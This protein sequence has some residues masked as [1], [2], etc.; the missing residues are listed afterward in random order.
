MI[1]NLTPTGGTALLPS[2]EA[3]LGVVAEVVRLKLQHAA[4]TAEMESEVTAVQKRFAARL[5]TLAQKIGERE[6]SVQ[7]YCRAHRAALFPDKK[8]LETPSALVG[9]ELNPWRVVTSG[10][11]VTWKD[12]LERLLRLPWG[13]SYVRTPAPVPDKEALLADREKLTAEQLTAAG[14]GFAQDEQFFIRP[15]SEIA[16]ATVKTE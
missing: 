4:L 5:D 14:V 7:H 11:K 13:R 1:A 2:R 16:E 9:F 12:V 3:M 10:R 8:S 15:K 6:T